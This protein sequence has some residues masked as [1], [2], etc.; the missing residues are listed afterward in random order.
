MTAAV[1][2]KLGINMSSSI[3]LMLWS[4][5][6]VIIV[7]MSLICVPKFIS[8]SLWKPAYELGDNSADRRYDGMLRR[9]T[10]VQFSA[11][12]EFMFQAAL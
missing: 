6:L 10:S 12:N 11:V 3:W 5:S 7:F 1:S 4:Y 8:V 2:G 9:Q